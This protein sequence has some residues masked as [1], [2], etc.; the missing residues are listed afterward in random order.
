MSVSSPK[1]PPGLK[2]YWYATPDGEEDWFVISRTARQARRWVVVAEGY[3]TGDVA[4]E[5]ILPLPTGLQGV[6]EGWPDRAVLEA[7]G[8]RFV[9]LETPRVVLLGNRTFSEGMLES[10]VLRATDDDHERRGLGRP[11]GTSRED[12]KA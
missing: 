4:V 9:R 3:E 5:L 6:G 2:L 10:K 7:L 12:P 1:K 8:G 11:N